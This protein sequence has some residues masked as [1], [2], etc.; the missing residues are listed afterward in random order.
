MTVNEERPK[1]SRRDPKTL[2]RLG[3]EHLRETEARVSAKSKKMQ[4]MLTEEVLRWEHVPRSR[5]TDERSGS[6][7]RAWSEFK[8]WSGTEWLH[9]DQ[10]LFIRVVYE[11]HKVK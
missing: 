7:D 5:V 11:I 8:K 10:A 6:K 1:F 9:T 3:V 4:A 2:A